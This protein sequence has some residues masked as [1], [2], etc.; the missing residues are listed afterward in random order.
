MSDTETTTE[1]PTGC[2]ADEALKAALSAEGEAP[3]STELEAHLATCERC[4]ERLD[5]L[6]HFGE[7]ATLLA[8]YDRW[9]APS[10][11]LD[12]A[13]HQLLSRDRNSATPSPAP[14]SRED[15]L[16]QLRPTDE[17]GALGK[18]GEHLVVHEILGQGGMGI[19]LRAR[20]T[21]LER[22]VAVKLL[23]PTFRDFPELLDRFREEARAVAALEHENVIPIHQVGE[24][25]N[26]LPYFVMPLA[27]GPTLAGR[28][29]ENG[30]PPFAE[31]LA[32]ALRASRAL[33]AAHAAGI[34][35]RDLKPGNL[36]LGSRA[37][38]ASV[39]LSDFGLASRAEK[40]SGQ[41][42]GGTPGYLAPEII[43]GEKAT[44]R[45]DLYS[46][47]CLFA[48]LA[49][50]DAPAWFL[51]LADRLRQ[52]DPG[53]RPASAAE[54][55]RLLED[56]VEAGQSR[57]YHRRLLVRS[58][59][60][61]GLAVAALAVM[62][63]LDLSGRTHFAN[64]ALRAISGDAFTIHG[65]F[66][67][68]ASLTGA[69]QATRDGDRILIHRPGPF[70]TAPTGVRQHGLA[71]EADPKL[72]E[73]PVLK[74]PD[75]QIGPAGMIWVMDGDLE[76]VG[77][78]LVHD[79]S[80]ADTNRRIPPLVRLQN[81]TLTLK[82]CHLHRSGLRPDSESPLALVSDCPRIEVSLCEF[83]S[84][85]GPCFQWRTQ[86]DHLEME[87]R[88]NDSRFA[89]R[90]W[91]DIAATAGFV[92]PLTRLDVAAIRCD[93]Q[94]PAESAVSYQRTQQPID[95]LFQTENCRIATSESGLIDFEF[96]NGQQLRRSVTLRDRGSL[97]SPA[98][99][100]PEG[101]RR[102]WQE[103]W[104][105]DSIDAATRWVD[106]IDFSADNSALPEP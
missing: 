33:A 94:T 77:I 74:M 87:I 21:A 98:P 58:L 13:L 27:K 57:R 81:G 76:L 28:L 49:G 37:D 56:R 80:K 83:E 59:P 31:S 3:L 71:I 2:P 32:I 17:A 90:Q 46:L 34:I 53:N 96:G 78:E 20:D 92:V 63:F 14:V 10:A 11:E 24:L 42:R 67:T 25:E 88:M 97:F 91:L 79:S 47:G 23:K 8:D 104:G 60:F 45:S 7:T 86:G 52:P 70:S 41:S 100:G 89:G 30:K 35:H 51:D 93:V 105:E 102:L 54:V 22:E 50:A 99:G 101:S 9:S 103:R 15:I 43:A 12:T 64:D 19:V 29:R 84:D 85:R 65:R 73:R 72:K 26:G 4:R 40:E 61:V 95:L 38:D 48:E 82:N 69:M 66:G 68:Y 75:D 6:A 36:L 106:V 39:W 5:E 16:A 55:V 18:L 44:N 62:A 1:I